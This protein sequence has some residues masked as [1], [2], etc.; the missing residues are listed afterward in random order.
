MN[1]PSCSNNAEMSFDRQML[2]TINDGIFDQGR[3][4]YNTRPD[5]RGTVQSY[6]V[7]N[8]SLLKGFAL[9]RIIVEWESALDVIARPVLVVP[10]A[11]LPCITEHATR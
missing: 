2:P 11:K 9:D 6:F 1:L 4:V 5:V 10:I 3:G 8:S 7:Q